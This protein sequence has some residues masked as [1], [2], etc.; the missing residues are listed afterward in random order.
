MHMKNLI[1]VL[2][3][4]TLSASAAIGQERGNRQ[5]PGQNRT[6]EER[7][8]AEVERLGTALNLDQ[9]QR[10]SIYKHSLEQTKKQQALF[11]QGGGDRE[12]RLEQMK[13]SRNEYDTKI[14]SF[15]TEDQIKKYEEV[16]KGRVQRRQARSKE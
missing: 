13:S 4:I 12:K 8:K 14:K 16:Q 7:A 10:D 5:G 9:S 11:Q 15:L 3:A 6:P 2:I 1:L